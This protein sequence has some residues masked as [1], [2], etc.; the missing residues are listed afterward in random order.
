V[1]D[2]GRDAG[3]PSHPFDSFD[4]SDRR[5]ARVGKSGDS[6]GTSDPSVAGDSFDPFES[7]DAHDR[8]AGR[9]PSARSVAHGGGGVAGGDAVGETVYTRSRRSPGSSSGEKSAGGAAGADGESDSA[10]KRQRPAR[11]LKG[12]ALGFL[13]RRE[14]SRA[15][16]SRKLAPYVEEG[17]S[18]DAVLDAL[19]QENW[20]SDSRF[21]ESLVHR[22]ASRLGAGRIIGELKHH[23]VSSTLI[24]ETAAQLRET[25]LARAQAVWRK[26]YG[27]LPETPAERA[28]QARFLMSRGFSQ[29][30]IVKILKGIDEDFDEGFGG[31]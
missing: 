12:R 7:F 3:G 4:R 9:G 2:S 24:E 30:I 25:E 19:Q 23:A 29:G 26:K 14:Y 11:S 27:Q 15:E 8:A 18:L 17:E 31:D 13:S 5:D 16:L 1:S 10:K 6:G 22:R 20:L 28:K 21:T